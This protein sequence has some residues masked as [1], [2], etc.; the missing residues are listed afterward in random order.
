MFFPKIQ[1]DQRQ[2]VDEKLPLKEE[3]HSN[4][5][6]SETV[7]LTK[8]PSLDHGCTVTEV[9]T[10]KEKPRENLSESMPSE[11]Q[12]NSDLK[13]QNGNAALHS[14]VVFEVLDRVSY[15]VVGV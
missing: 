15:C 1:G 9:L 8:P 4:M 14:G 3:E 2:N 7:L 10:D 6:N 11:S 5:E 12:L 13:K